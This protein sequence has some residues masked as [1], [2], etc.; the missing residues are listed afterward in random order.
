MTI[1]YIYSGW[2]TS[3]DWSNY[4]SSND[5]LV[6]YFSLGIKCKGSDVSYLNVLYNSGT[7]LKMDRLPKTYK[8]NL[9]LEK[10][11]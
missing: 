5:L 7:L 9:A 10:A 11:T 3:T 1:S 2:L 4:W 8:P 6:G